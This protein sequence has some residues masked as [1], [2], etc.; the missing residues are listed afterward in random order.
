M[1]LTNIK[2]L[3]TWFIAQP[4]AAGFFTLEPYGQTVWIMNQNV[5]IRW[6]ENKEYP[7][8]TDIH[9]FQIELCSGSDTR[10][11]VLGTIGEAINPNTTKAVSFIV[12]NV[13]PPGKLYFLRYK[14]TPM[15][16]KSLRPVYFW[17]TR[18]TIT[19]GNSMKPSPP[20]VGFGMVAT[21]APDNSRLTNTDFSTNSL[22]ATQTSDLQGT[23]KTT[24]ANAKSMKNGDT[25]VGSGVSLLLMT[26]LT[27]HLLRHV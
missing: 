16:S 27:V 19:D 10:Q 2:L 8:L 9:P 24:A 17:S 25:R 3:L 13:S 14:A 5:T 12:P 23:M 21:P 26:T 11:V 6:I 1:L 7:L 22:E 4:V 20:T 18:F 15:Q